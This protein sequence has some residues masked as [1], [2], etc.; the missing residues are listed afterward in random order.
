MTNA[1]SVGALAVVLGVALSG[2]S[3]KAGE[4]DVCV[5]VLQDFWIPPVM[6][7]ERTC[8]G[9]PE[10]LGVNLVDPLAPAGICCMPGICMS[11]PTC[12]VAKN[13]I[14]AAGYVAHANEVHCFQ[15]TPE[16]L[17]QLWLDGLVSL[18][19]D[20]LSG[21]L[22]DAT[23]QLAEA[24]IEHLS[25]AGT[26]LP[27]HVRN[28][29]KE[30]VASIYDNGVTGFEYR[31][32]DD[33]KVLRESYNPST[34]AW[35]NGGH[36]A[37]TLGHLIVLEDALVNELLNT[38]RNVMT[39][40]DLRRGGGS[41]E[42]MQALNTLLHEMVHVKQYE[43]LGMRTFL[44]DYVIDVALSGGYGFDKFE[45]EAIGYEARVFGVLGSR[46]CESIKGHV[47]SSIVTYNV[48]AILLTCTHL[49]TKTLWNLSGAA[50]AETQYSVLLP[51]DAQ[52]L[53][54]VMTGSGDADLYL[55]KAGPP[56]QTV[57][58]ARPFSGTSNETIAL[59]GA[60]PGLY[61][62]MVRGW[63]AYSGVTLALSYDAANFA[64]GASLSGLS[65][66]AGDTKLYWVDVSGGTAVTFQ[67]AGGSGDADLYVR[68]EQ[69]P[70]PNQW[71]YRPYL[72][73]NNETVTTSVD[74]SGS[75]RWYAMVR[76]YRD[77]TGLIFATTT[78]AC[79]P[80][81]SGTTCG[82]DGCGGSC[83]S[84]SGNQSCIAGNCVCIPN[85]RYKTCG[86][87]G[88]GGSCGSCN[89]R[90]CGSQCVSG[91]VCP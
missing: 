64:A 43:R 12:T 40:D 34:D 10:C 89:G 27:L 14:V 20:A 1:R 26:S 3:A 56:S 35:L 48:P 25:L 47:N 19:G 83:G 58:D 91:K 38:D 79:T 30:M 17:W 9:F 33:V 61:Y 66:V 4:Y 16:D 88:C 67:I 59:T 42:F 15:T 63:Q 49:N 37:I 21:G 18:G 68:A 36:P 65:G 13:I 32:L 53:K 41:T 77:Y 86:P 85:C 74:A 70:T 72:G 76:S 23:M 71:N 6:G 62:L 90:C 82:P 54:V 55:R 51:S 31:S 73:S 29:L 57:Y 84:C 2:A 52:N 80:V 81:C 75:K 44:K 7:T 60:T 39:L 69:P 5:E 45:Q 22:L 28:I 46:F 87:D 24:D 50:G 78:S 11:Y 8:L